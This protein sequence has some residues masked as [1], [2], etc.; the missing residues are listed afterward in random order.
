MSYKW[1]DNRKFYY[2]YNKKNYLEI[3]PNKFIVRAKSIL[4]KQGL[5]DLIGKYKS[6]LDIKELDGLDFII[7]SKEN[8]EKSS[9]FFDTF[10]DSIEF[11][12]PVYLYR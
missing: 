6:E 9:N 8:F 12:K 7:I 1:V 4:N 3:V 10:S 5:I 11:L 2:A